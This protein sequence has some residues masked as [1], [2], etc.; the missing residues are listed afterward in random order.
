MTKLQQALL[1]RLDIRI[2]ESALS[3]DRK[4]VHLRKLINITCKTGSFRSSQA[5]FLPTQCSA[6]HFL[7]ASSLN[8]MWLKTLLW[9]LPSFQF[10]H[11]DFLPEI[12]PTQPP[13]STSQY[14]SNNNDASLKLSIIWSC[15]FTQTVQCERLNQK[16]NS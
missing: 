8:F 13:I 5:D 9:H 11:Q 7:P 15:H 1:M 12:F 6:Y 16:F 3:K 2:F 14:F 4:E 10:C